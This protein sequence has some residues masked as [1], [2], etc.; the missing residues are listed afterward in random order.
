MLMSMV[1]YQLVTT[2]P[3]LSPFSPTTPYHS[4]FWVYFNGMEK[5][6]AKADF[7]VGRP[8]SLILIRVIGWIGLGEKG[9]MLFFSF[10]SFVAIS[11]ILL[12]CES[13]DGRTVKIHLRIF[14][15]F[16]IMT[17]PTYFQIYQEDFGG[18][19]ATIFFC[20]SLV[21]AGKPTDR[22]GK[23]IILILMWLSFEFK[24]TWMASAPIAF[25]TIWLVNKDR[26]DSLFL[27]IQVVVLSV[28][29]LLK[30][31]F[32]NSGFIN[33]TNVDAA[34]KIGNLWQIVSTYKSYAANALTTPLLA[35]LGFTLLFFKCNYKTILVVLAVAVGAILPIATLVNHLMPMYSWYASPFVLGVI[36]A[37]RSA[38]WD[39]SASSRPMLAKYA[40][41]F[42]YFAVLIAIM[43]L[44]VEQ[45]NGNVRNF[46]LNS[47]EIIHGDLQALNGIK[48][49]PRGSKVLVG[50]MHPWSPFNNWEYI[51]RI[52]GGRLQFDYLVRD[53]FVWTQLIPPTAIV[54]I[55]NIK[56]EDYDYFLD[57][58][59]PTGAPALVVVLDL[60]MEAREKYMAYLYCPNLSKLRYLADKKPEKILEEVK[61][62][63]DE[64]NPDKA[65]D[66]LHRQWKFLEGNPWGSFVEGQ[67]YEAQGKCQNAINSYR[68]AIRIDP[69]LLFVS[70][71]SR[72]EN[73]TC[74]Q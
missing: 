42:G 20:L 5:P 65:L 37:S 71:L 36:V 14:Y 6:L 11:L 27:A 19:A 66:T 51:D 1:V 17:L 26:K 28:I 18:I 59:N 73:E 54:Q 33:M 56:A 13:I 48:D 44:S 57:L 12:A 50:A 53:D 45:I 55:N 23:I 52:S 29:I 58:S 22:A 40:Y 41:I 68:Q 25:G 63:V 16:I 2:V 72:L 43:M 30:D 38:R 7:L 67:V 47:Q 9:A 35:T 32:L 64:G 62:L 69:N 10:L 60:K 46:I 31:I 15:V 8:L 24:P 61:C 21:V 39:S 34:Y 3:V 74:I 70:T 49:L 4:D